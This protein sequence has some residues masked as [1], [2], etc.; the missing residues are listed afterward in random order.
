MRI[1]NPQ[2]HHIPALRSLWQE[3]FGDTEE[4]LDLF[5]SKAFSPDRCRCVLEEDTPLAALY[6]FDETCRGQP[7]AYLYAVATRKAYRG[8]GLCR[9]LLT[10]THQDLAG[11]GYGGALLVP[12]NEDLARMYRK[13]GYG[14]FGGVA[15]IP[16]SAGSPVPLWRI[17]PEEFHR[18]REALLPEGGVSLDPNYLPFLETQGELYAGEDFLLTVQWEDGIPVGIELL[19]NAA[20]APGIVAALG[21]EAGTFRTPGTGKTFAMYH[22][23]DESPPPSYFGLGFQ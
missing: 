2:P 1:E 3:A 9:E 18:R 16:A 14:F 20:A 10:H 5:F 4:F 17:S 12:A 11:L 15:D 13:L 8:R 21:A 23:L 22:S 7:V 19:G 6:W